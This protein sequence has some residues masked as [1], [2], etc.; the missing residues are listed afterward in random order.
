MS[1]FLD[2]ESEMREGDN[3]RDHDDDYKGDDVANAADRAF[4]R[5]TKSKKTGRYN[6]RVYNFEST[7]RKGKRKLFNVRRADEYKSDYAAYRAE[8]QQEREEE[9]HGRKSKRQKFLDAVKNKKN[10]PTSFINKIKNRK[11]KN[12]NNNNNNNNGIINRLRKKFNLPRKKYSNKLADLLAK[13]HGAIQS[14]ITD[15]IQDDEDDDDDYNENDVQH[16]RKRKRKRVSPA[17]QQLLYMDEDDAA[18]HYAKKKSKV[19]GEDEAEYLNHIAIQGNKKSKEVKNLLMNVFEKHVNDYFPSRSSAIIKRQM[20]QS[21]RNMLRRNK[22]GKWVAKFSDIITQANKEEAQRDPRNVQEIVST[23]RLGEALGEDLNPNNPNKDRPTKGR[24][25]AAEQCKLP[26]ALGV[27]EKTTCVYETKINNDQS[28]TEIKTENVI[29]E[30]GRKKEV[31]ALIRQYHKDGWY[32]FK[33]LHYD[34]EQFNNFNMQIIFKKVLPPIK[35]YN[36][37]CRILPYVGKGGVV[38]MRMKSICANC[39]HEKNTIIKHDVKKPESIFK[40]GEIMKGG[41]IQFIQ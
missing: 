21:A 1:R 35:T 22:K 30:D 23:G 11:H 25:N 37:N 7:K 19:E 13:K 26:K 32:I 36:L 15:S 29:W 24:R 41:A 18:L 27:S 40:G 9:L 3:P 5:N 16:S 33:R 31:Q 38:K 2:L 39:H 10:K 8:L 14:K 4:L 12:N 34:K 28:N 17:D 6:A 20:I